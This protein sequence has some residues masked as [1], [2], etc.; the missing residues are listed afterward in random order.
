LNSNVN[1]SQRF[2]IRKPM[3]SV[4]YSPT[5]DL[6]STIKNSLKSTENIRQVPFD[7]HQHRRT[8]RT[9]N[10]TVSPTT[11]ELLPAIIFGKRFD[12]PLGNH[13]YL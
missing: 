4:H 7:H 1:S 5:G 13:R 10:R 12:I 3:E 9:S 2:F 6:L 8:R 11:I